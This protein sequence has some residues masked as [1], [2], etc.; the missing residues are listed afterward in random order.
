MCNESFSK[1]YPV[2]MLGM[3]HHENG[4]PSLPLAECIVKICADVLNSGLEDR[5]MPGVKAK[6][7]VEPL[8]VELHQKTLEFFKRYAAKCHRELFEDHTAEKI[9]YLED[10]QDDAES[11][12]P[13]GQLAA[14][15]VPAHSDLFIERLSISQFYVKFNYRSYRLSM[16]KL[17]KKEIFEFLN[18]ADIRDLIITFKRFDG[19]GYNSVEKLV[20]ELTDYYTYDILN[21]QLLTCVTAV[22]PIRSITNIMSGFIDIFRLP[23]RSYRKR[24]RVWS[25][26]TEGVSSFISKLSSETKLIGKVV[27]ALL[28]LRSSKAFSKNSPEIR[29]RMSLALKMCFY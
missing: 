15:H 2:P 20:K 18:I 1:G 27:R 12:E 21:N 13:K 10:V 11:D 7:K 3:V 25:G 19:R 24:R 4:R 8:N 17:Y 22:S 16:S 29:G 23:I 6:V 28:N 26:L 9:D 14:S 5:V